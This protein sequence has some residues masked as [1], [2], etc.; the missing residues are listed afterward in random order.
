MIQHSQM[1]TIRGGT[2]IKN[3]WVKIDE[4]KLGQQNGNGN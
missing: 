2:L 1:G 4:Q 3:F